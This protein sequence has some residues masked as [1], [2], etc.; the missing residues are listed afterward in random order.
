M[1]ESG[2][3]YTVTCYR[4]QSGYD[5]LEAGWCSCLV[6]ETTLVCPSCL[7]CFCDAPPAF[8]SSFWSGAPRGLWDRKFALHHG[9]YQPPANPEPD[10]AA[11]PLVLVVDDERAIQRVAAR[12][13]ESLGYGVVLGRNGQEGLDLVRRYHPDL[14]LTDALM[15]RMDGREMCRLIKEDPDTSATPVVVMTS[16]YTGVRYRNEAHKVHRVDDYLAKPL[17]FDALR[18][19][20]QRHLERSAPATEEARA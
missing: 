5:A 3:T 6:A 14:V 1:S 16:L 7:G 20:L 15:P 17:A 2:Q 4:C 19:V 9:E 18:S 12:A 13:I 11:R 10:E 8:K